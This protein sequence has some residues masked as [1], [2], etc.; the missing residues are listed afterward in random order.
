MLK[1][2]NALTIVNNN[3]SKQSIARTNDEKE[4]HSQ[5]DELDNVYILS[6]NLRGGIGLKENNDKDTVYVP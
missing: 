3:E 6:G 2:L 1:H 4:E 5:S